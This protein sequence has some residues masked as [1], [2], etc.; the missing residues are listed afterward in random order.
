MSRDLELGGVPVF[1]P[2]RKNFSDFDEIW[3]VHTGRR[4]MHGTM[5]YDPIQVMGPLEVPKIALFK[6]H[7]LHHLQREV[8]NDH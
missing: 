1:S 2:Y 5:L 7:L 4:V 3:Y 6:V 8:A